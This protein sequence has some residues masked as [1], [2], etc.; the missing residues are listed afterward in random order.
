[1]ETQKQIFGLVE[2]DLASGIY[3]GKIIGFPHIEFEATSVADLVGK[4]QAHVVKLVNSRS[5]VL[6]SEFI[7]VFRL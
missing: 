5:L 4:L 2:R 7:G 6:E 3:I 1:M